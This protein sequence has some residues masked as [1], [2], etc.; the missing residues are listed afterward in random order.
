MTTKT[1]KPAKT[2][3][4]SATASA[5]ADSTGTAAGK[6]RIFIVDDHPI[7]R[8]GL[9][10]LINNE[11]D[12]VVSGQGEE[13]YESLRAIRQNKPALVLVDVLLKTATA[14]NY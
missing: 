9:A 8:Q 4:D 11:P 12:L 1:T 2:S 5:A 14:S 7:V 10:Q 6:R 3:G 13:A